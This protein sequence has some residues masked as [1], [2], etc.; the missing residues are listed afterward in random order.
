[1]LNVG[2]ARHCLGDRVFDDAATTEIYTAKVGKIT[3]W[4]FVLIG[5]PMLLFLFLT[6]RR[7]IQQLGRLT[8]LKQEEILLPR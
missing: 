7:L 1:M 8:G 5:V 6:L 4:G 2:L 3:W